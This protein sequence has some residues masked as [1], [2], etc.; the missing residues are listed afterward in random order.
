MALPIRD[1][2]TPVTLPD[3]ELEKLEASLPSPFDLAEGEVRIAYSEGAYRAELELCARGVRVVTRSRS[4]EPLAAVRAT[5]QQMIERARTHGKWILSQKSEGTGSES[6]E[7]ATAK[8]RRLE[9]DRD[10]GDRSVRPIRA[11]SLERALVE[12]ELSGDA[13]FLY[14]DAAGDRL[15][16]LARSEDGRIE[17]TEL[18][19]GLK[20]PAKPAAKAAAPSEAQP[21]KAARGAAKK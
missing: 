4:G 12:W 6:S 3:G 10:E 15:A 16:I 2:G 13:A 17:R 8:A 20:H 1:S 7:A 19:K 11:L 9:N 5:F 18:P 14:W 21:A